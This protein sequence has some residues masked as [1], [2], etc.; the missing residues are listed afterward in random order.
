MLHP[1]YHNIHERYQFFGCPTAASTYE[2]LEAFARAVQGAWMECNQYL[3][4]LADEGVDRN[5]WG[6]FL[7]RYPVLR[8][9]G[10][11]AAL[12]YVRVIPD[13]GFC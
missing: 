6:A 2:I 1:R 10:N 13:L 7:E 3:Q 9:T 11:L 8:T 5:R 4:Q 12:R